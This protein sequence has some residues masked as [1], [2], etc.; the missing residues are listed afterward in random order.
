MSPDNKDSTQSEKLA[1]LV[2][3][4][5]KILT[6][7][8][9]EILKLRYLEGKTAAETGTVFK[10]HP[11]RI[12]AI[13]AKGIRKIAHAASRHLQEKLM[14]LLGNPTI[15]D[16]QQKTAFNDSVGLNEDIINAF[17]GSSG[18]NL[19]PLAK[20]HP[21]TFA[22]ALSHVNPDADKQRVAQLANDLIDLAIGTTRGA[23]RGRAGGNG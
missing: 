23:G 1:S 4:Y 19:R 18:S 9:R 10:V 5:G 12:K 14:A 22:E 3:K 20:L 7:R 8:E 17:L 2:E 15:E 11:N 6:Y 21:E 13:E 16:F